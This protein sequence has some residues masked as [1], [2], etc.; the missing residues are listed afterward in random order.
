MI[1]TYKLRIY[2]NDS[3]AKELNALISFWQEEVNHKIKIF[4]DF[5][6]VEGSYPPKEYTKGGRLIRDASV[7][8]W[9]TV[10]GAKKAEQKER[11]F[12]NEKEID[13]NEFSAH[14][15]QDFTTK[16]FD[17]WLNVISLDSKQGRGNS[18]RIKLPCKKHREFNKALEIGE[19]RKS[20]KISRDGKNYY[21][22]FFFVVP[23]FTKANNRIVG[24]DVGMTHPAVM[25]DGRK[26][27]DELRNLRIR[28]KWRQYNRGL[29]AYKQGLNIIAKKI[30]SAYPDCNFAVERLLFKGKGKR[31][32]RFRRNNNTWAYAYLSHRLE[33]IGKEKGFLLHKVNPA[34]SSQQ[35]PVC[36]FTSRSNRISSEDFCC[37]QCGFKGDADRIGA[38]NLCERVGRNI[39]SDTEIIG[40]DILSMRLGTEIEKLSEKGIPAKITP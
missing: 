27:G 30:V 6:K 20:F 38:L 12:F 8:A 16:K 31:S 40:C 9:Q 19:L 24:I 22:T 29:S 32:R 7:K 34:Y 2:P 10:K 36:G 35:C 25:S 21:A 28:T 23:E 13:L 14:V 1:K 26:F 18:K 39:R 4:W 11:P 17:L 5:N 37:G 3:K 15:I 33:E